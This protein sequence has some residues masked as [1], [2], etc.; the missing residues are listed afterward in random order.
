[1]GISHLH[2]PFPQLWKALAKRP[3]RVIKF[4]NILVTVV[5][6]QPDLSTLILPFVSSG[7]WFGPYEHLPMGGCT[8]EQLLWA[9]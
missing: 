1:M 5:S 6:L 3:Y 4:Q 7:Q 9:Q 8:L 2:S